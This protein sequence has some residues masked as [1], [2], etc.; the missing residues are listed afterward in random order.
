[1]ADYRTSTT[2]ESNLMIEKERCAENVKPVPVAAQG[3]GDLLQCIG[4][5]CA[6][7]IP[8]LVVSKVGSVGSLLS[9]RG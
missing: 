4:H 9:H 8:S 5:F 1:M 3:Y 7:S 2:E 6:F